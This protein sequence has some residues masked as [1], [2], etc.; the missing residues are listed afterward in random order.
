MRPAE[1]FVRELAPHE[2]QRLKRLSKQ[3][4]VAS[5]RQ[6]AMIL[7]ASNTL[8]SAPAGSRS[9]A[10][11]SASG[12]AIHPRVGSL[13]TTTSLPP[14]SAC[15]RTTGRRV[16][17]SSTRSRPRTPRRRPV[18]SVISGVS[19]CMG[20]GGEERRLRG[21]GV[22]VCRGIVPA[23]IPASRSA[24]SPSTPARTTPRAPRRSAPRNSRATRPTARRG[25]F[26]P[27]RTTPRTLRRSARRNAGITLPH[28]DE[29]LARERA[30]RLRHTGS[31]ATTR[32]R[33]SPPQSPTALRDGR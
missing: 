2:G 32:G 27:A 29:I 28:P 7:V 22:V 31:G 26:T 33:R 21:R 10:A 6:R 14:G 3:S 19:A 30:E 23:T 15:R 12:S 5:T 25:A 18:M 1:V 17:P 16:G 9:P 13:V 4:K 20:T 24:R 8:M 11:P